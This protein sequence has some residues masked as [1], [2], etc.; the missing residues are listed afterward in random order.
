MDQ[1][2]RF[3][4]KVRVGDRVTATV[5]LKEKEGKRAVFRTV[6]S[7]HHG[8]QGSEEGDQVAVEGEAKALLRR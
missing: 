6:V 8:G 5:T 2:L 1:T 7:L 3:K 4:K